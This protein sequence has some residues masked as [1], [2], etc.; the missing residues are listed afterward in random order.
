MKN[1]NGNSSDYEVGY[2]KPPKKNRFRKGKS[3]NPRGRPKGAQN[4]TGI[5]NDLLEKPVTVVI[6]GVKQQMAGRNALAFKIFEKALKGDARA[7][8]ILREADREITHELLKE[9]QQ[10]EGETSKTQTDKEIIDH[11]LRTHTHRSPKT[12]ERQHEK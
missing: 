10:A 8:E 6:E 5:M 4:L 1:K 9:Q 3:G 12:K 2:K 7:I 11:F